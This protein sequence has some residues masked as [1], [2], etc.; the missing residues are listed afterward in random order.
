MVAL[1]PWRVADLAA[2]VRR[3]APFAELPDSA[4]HAVLDML[5]GRYPS[6]AFAE[7]RPR[8]VWDRADRPAHRPARRAAARRHQRRHHPRPRALRRLPG[9]RRARRPG[10]RA[11]RGDGLRVPRRRRLPAR[12]LL[13]AHRGDHPRPG[14]GL[15]R[16]RAGRPDAV[17]EGRLARAARSS[18]AGPSA[19]GCAALARPTTRP[20]RRRAARGR[21]G[22]VGRRQPAGVPARAAGRHPRTCPTTGPSWSSASAT[23]WAT[24]GSPCTASSAPGST[25]PGRWPSPAGWPNGTAWTPRCCPPT[26]ASWSGCRTPPTSRPAP[27]WSPSTPTRSPSWS[28]SPSAPRRSS[29]S[30]FREC[31]ARSLLLPRRDPRRRQPLWQQRQRAA[32][33]LDVAREYAD[34]PVTLEAARECL[35]DV[36]DVPGAGRADAR[37]RR[38]QGPAG[39]GGDTAPVTVR[40]LAAL[41]LRRRLPL[42]GRRAAGRAPGRRAGPGLHPARR[43]ARPGRPARTARPGGARRDRARSCAGCTEQRRPATPEDAGRAA[44]GARR[45]LRRRAGRARR[46]PPAWLA[47]LAGGPPGRCGTDRRA[48]ALDRRRGRRPATAT[49]SAWRCRSGWPQA[50]LEPVADPLGDLVARYARTHGPF[51]AADLRG[52]LRSRRRSSSSRPCAGS[53]PPGG[54]SPAS[55]PRGGGAARAVVRRR[56]AAPAAPPLAG[57][58]A[59]GDRAGAAAGAG[60]ASCPAGSRSAPPARGR[61]RASPPPWSSCRAWRCRR[62]RWSAWCCRP[63]SP[64]TPPPTSTSSAPAARCSGPGPARS[65]AATAGSRLAYADS[66]AAAAPAAGRG[67][68]RRPRCTRRCSTRSTTGRRSSSGRWPTGSARLDDAELTARRSGTW[69]GPGSSPTTRSPR[70]GRCSAAA[71]AHRSR[72]A[73]APHPLPPARPGGAARRGPARRSV[74]RPL[75]PAARPRS[76]PDPAGRRRSPT[77][78][79]ERHGVVTR[80]AVVAEQVTGGFAAV[81]PVLSALEERGAARRGYFVEGLGAAQFAR[82]GRGGPAARPA[83]TRRR[84]RRARPRGARRHRPGEPVRRGAALAGPGGRLRRRRGRPAPGTG[85]GARRARWWC[86]STATWCS[87]SNAAAGPSCRSPTTP[88]ALAAAGQGARR[89]AVHS[90]ALGA[91]S[92]ERA[93]GEAGARLTAARRADRRRFPGHAARPAPARLT[94][95]R[96]CAHGP[97]PAGRE[98]V[99]RSMRSTRGR[100]PATGASLRSCLVTTGSASPP[101]TA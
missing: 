66:A 58:A 2:L 12:L 68:W 87:T 35:Q 61:G 59:P 63:G 38:P 80:G 28:R 13:L 3:A 47:E 52:P 21:P 55:S 36:F 30:R 20:R 22:R 56:G 15:A 71:G 11:R 83:P 86:W 84:R 23:S 101:T 18:W 81:Y 1:D 65:P 53:P 95:A 6:T 29:P 75:V 54:W 91:I 51:T 76:R 39:R 31:A 94:A 72:P 37:P 41:R 70:C 77:L 79:L 34:F 73:R 85:P 67:D 33:L 16:A 7:L 26:T 88:D 78:L 48:G 98:V 62:P 93:D 49:R 90:G 5:S 74:G 8:L 32:Q 40:P 4:L 42:R 45:P 14:A 89:D 97:R 82:A 92:V 17:L 96:A 60:R 57:R 43:A 99:S 100:G 10:R 50:Y 46:R 25:R 19:P 69:S 24:G 9:R 27:T 64:T 44:A